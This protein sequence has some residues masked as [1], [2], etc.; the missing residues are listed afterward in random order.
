MKANMNIIQRVMKLAM[1]A[2]TLCL[3]A[4]GQVACSSDNEEAR[5]PEAAYQINKTALEVN[6]TM[7]ITFTGVADQVVVFTGDDMHEYVKRAESNTGFVVNKGVFTY[8][9][10]TP[11]TYTVTVIASTYDTYLGENQKIDIKE[12]QVTVEDNTCTIEGISATVNPNVYIAEAVNDHDWV[13]CTPTM[14]LNN[15]REVKFKTTGQRIKFDMGTDNAEIFVDGSETAHDYNKSKYDLSKTYQLHVVAPSGASRDY[16]LYGMVY[17][18]LTN[19]KVGDQTLT[20]VRNAYYQDMLTYTY[21]AL[22]ETAGPL[23]LTYTADADAVFYADGVAMP[24]GS[25]IDLT[26]ENV[27]YTLVRTNAENAA[28]TATTRVFFAPAE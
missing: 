24:S 27:E 23:K 1:A 15:G 17:P 7:E 13:I 21:P 22:Q 28:V 8:A 12:F 6:E 25:D 3:M 20:L 4:V 16:T 11:G 5:T 26:K 2:L 19:V 9:Y 10:R 14:Q 18:E